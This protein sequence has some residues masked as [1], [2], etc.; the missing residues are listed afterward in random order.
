MEQDVHDGGVDGSNDVHVDDLFHDV[1]AASHDAALSLKLN[2]KQMKL[3]VHKLDE[4]S[5]NSRIDRDSWESLVNE[6]L[7]KKNHHSVG[8]SAEAS[9]QS[10]RASY[11]SSDEV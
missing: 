2:R 9:T 6:V 1:M 3:F 8:R 11:H 10:G 4:D 7:L 5:S